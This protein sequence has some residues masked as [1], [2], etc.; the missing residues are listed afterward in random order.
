MKNQVNKLAAVLVAGVLGLGSMAA[1]AAEDGAGV[2]KYAKESTKSAQQALE[3][4][5]S[6][7]KTEAAEALKMTRQHLKEVTGDY[8]GM[9]LQRANGRIKDAIKA[10]DSGDMSTANTKLEEGLAVLKEI[11]AKATA[12]INK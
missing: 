12:Q 8:I 6:G 4:V 2:L 3:Y 1:M 10:V 5:K 9:Q 7:H 11:E